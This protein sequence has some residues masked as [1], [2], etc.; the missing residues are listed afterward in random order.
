MEST[1][2]RS[3]DE[4]ATSHSVVTKMSTAEWWEHRQEEIAQEGREIIGKL[5]EHIQQN[6]SAPDHSEATAIR[7][8]FGTDNTPQYDAACTAYRNIDRPWSDDPE[9]NAI[10]SETFA[11]MFSPPFSS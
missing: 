6:R 10:A 3:P 11:R 4:T 2:T 8:G 9:L 7:N 1:I 5:F